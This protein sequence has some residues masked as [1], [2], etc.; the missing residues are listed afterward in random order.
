MSEDTELLTGR[1]GTEAAQGYTPMPEANPEPEPAITD[2]ELA[3]FSRPPEA[4]WGRHEERAYVDNNDP[5]KRR[6]E[7]ETVEADRAAEDLTAIR[8]AER[9]ARERELDEATAAAVDSLR[10][11][12]QDPA[13][14]PQQAQPEQQPAQP[15]P[16][17]EP[18]PEE[19]QFQQEQAAIAE[20]DKPIDEVLKD[21]WI[22]QRI[23]TEFNGV[24]AQA[25]AEVEQAQDGLHSSR[26]TKCARR[27]GRFELGFP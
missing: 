4:D 22:R 13:G 17:L 11:R 27:P 21:P 5:S 14:Q 26:P 19:L 3:H 2:R 25:A 1:A 12:V 8:K 18:Q 15:D 23:E 10:Q 7:R 6:A 20:A 9:N 16:N 24:K